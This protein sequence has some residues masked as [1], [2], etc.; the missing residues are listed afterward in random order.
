MAAAA[1]CCSESLRWR[2]QLGAAL[3]SPPNRSF[4]K[5]LGFGGP[6]ASLTACVPTH[7]AHAAC[8]TDHT[9]EAV[10]AGS[11]GHTRSHERLG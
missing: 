1:P 3:R 6:A 4:G 9:G 11:S 10:A 2:A 7:R 5:T 8:S